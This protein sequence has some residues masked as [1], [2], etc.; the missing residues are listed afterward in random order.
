M[1][2]PNQN[3][4]ANG[5]SPVESP[6]LLDGA[7]SPRESAMLNAQQKSLDQNAMNKSGGK[8]YKGG[9]GTMQV[10][11]FSGPGA[12]A[13]AGSVAANT[14]SSQGGANA[15]CDK[16]FGDVSA[17]EPTLRATCQ[18]PECNPT[19][20]GGGCSSCGAGGLIPNG[21]TW[22]CVGGGKRRKNMK[23]RKMKK[24]KRMKIKQ[25]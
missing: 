5:V 1:S 22:G 21:Q 2:F 4:G 13:N 19:Q 15:V 25:N 11:Q 10:P 23:S 18:G 16:C 12:G 6:P 3:S 17:M 14:T 9:S 7:S 20:A 24:S 8:K